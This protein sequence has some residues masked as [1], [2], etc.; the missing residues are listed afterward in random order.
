MF[1]ETSPRPGASARRRAQPKIFRLTNQYCK[2][3]RQSGRLRGWKRNSCIC[4]E[5]SLA[6]SPKTA[7]VTL[8]TAYCIAPNT[9]SSVVD[10][11]GLS[12]DTLFTSPATGVH[13][14]LILSISFPLVVYQCLVEICP[15][16]LA[17]PRRSCHGSFC[18]PLP[19][20][21]VQ[22]IDPKCSG[23]RSSLGGGKKAGIP[24]ASSL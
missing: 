15:G 3:R 17:R 2:A 23:D 7:G 13:A 10:V 11:V 24:P 19:P 22:R 18:S 21:A 14:S 4:L 5:E 12:A 1:S 20:I 9:F 6:T 16:M 8:Q